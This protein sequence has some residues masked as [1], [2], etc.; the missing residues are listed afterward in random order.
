[1]WTYQT[2]DSD[3]DIVGVTGSIPVAPTILK[4]ITY[5]YLFTEPMLLLFVQNGKGCWIVFLMKTCLY[6]P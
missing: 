2:W 1:M 6:T 3:V 4:S 5:E